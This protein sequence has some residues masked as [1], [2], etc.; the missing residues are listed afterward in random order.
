MIDVSQ[1]RALADDAG[2]AASELD[3]AL[4]EG[5]AVAAGAGM[6]EGR[7]AAA[8]KLYTGELANGIFTEGPSIRPSPD[9]IEIRDAIFSPIPHAAI[10]DTG[11]RAGARWPPP[12]P[13][14]RWVQL[15]AQRGQLDLSWTGKTGREAVKSAAFRIRAAI[16]RRGLPPRGVF[17]RAKE[18]AERELQDL[19]EAL[20]DSFR[21]TIEG[22]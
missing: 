13:I 2:V 20:A 5:V 17:E 7:I 16:S 15:R 22:R 12:G 4:V 3:Q 1:L 9:G 19:V 10:V 21:Q 14:E 11:R 6:R 8:E 18:T